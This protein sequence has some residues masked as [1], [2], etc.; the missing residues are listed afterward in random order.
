MAADFY[1][2]CPKKFSGKICFQNSKQ[3]QKYSIVKFGT[4]IQTYKGHHLGPNLCIHRDSANTKMTFRNLLQTDRISPP[5]PYRPII[6]LGDLLFPVSFSSS[7]LAPNRFLPFFCLPSFSLV[8]I[9]R[10]V[11]C[12]SIGHYVGL[13][14]GRSVCLSVSLSVVQQLA[15]YIYLYF[16]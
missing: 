9:F 16:F 11:L 3:F 6:S 12:D 7:P 15:L 1:Q 13:S 2:V 14:V 4:Y 8:L 5:C 10:C